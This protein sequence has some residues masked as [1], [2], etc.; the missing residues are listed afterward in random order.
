MRTIYRPEDQII[1]K[2]WLVGLQKN[3]TSSEIT[4]FVFQISIY[5]VTS[6]PQG[7]SL[8]QKRKP[9]CLDVINVKFYNKEKKLFRLCQ[10]IWTLNSK[11]SVMHINSQVKFNRRGK[12]KIM[13]SWYFSIL[14]SSGNKITEK[15]LWC[16]NVTYQ[17]HYHCDHRVGEILSLFP[18]GTI[19]ARFLAWETETRLRTRTPSPLAGLS[20]LSG[21]R[22][23]SGDKRENNREFQTG[24]LSLSPVLPSD[25][26]RQKRAERYYHQTS[27]CNSIY[28][29]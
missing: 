10:V 7:Q 5:T 18:A 2:G 12:M 19:K 21:L 3:K 24:F 29:F 26:F 22:T 4:G 9:N 8:R 28:I 23:A 27:H 15:M 11:Y 14:I 17:H 16:L 20:L 1:N 13:R 6:F 25:L